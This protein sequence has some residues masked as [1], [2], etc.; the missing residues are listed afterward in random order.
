[1]R[2]RPDASGSGS[3]R[4]F[5]TWARRATY[6]AHS[7]EQPAP[8]YGGVVTIVALMNGGALIGAGALA[9]PDTSLAWVCALISLVAVPGALLAIAFVPS[10]EVDWPEWLTLAAGLGVLA[11]LLGML[12]LSYLPIRLGPMVMVTWLSTL[13]PALGALALKRNL[14]WRAPAGCGRP[15]LL[16]VLLLLLVAAIP[17]LPGL[18]YSEFQGDETEVILQATGIVQGLTDTLFYHGK[19]PG[20][21]LIVAAQYGL[22]GTLSEGAARLPFALAGLFG[23]LAVYLAAHRLLGRAGALVAGLFIATNGY[24]VAFSRITQYQ[25][26]VFLLGVLAVWCALRWAQGGTSI[27]PVLAGA[28]AAG[29]ALAHYDAVFVLPPIALIAL[30]RSGPRMLLDWRLMRPWLTGAGV[31]LAI[32][33]CFFGPY[34]ASPLYG[35]ATSRIADRVGFGFPRNNLSAIAASALL[36]VS[37]I[38]LALLAVA[39]VPGG[40]LAVVQRLR[41]GRGAPLS[42]A[43]PSGRAWLVG[44]VWCALPLLFYAFVARKPGTHVHVTSLGL[45]ILAGAGT[46]TVWAM[47]PVA[48]RWVRAGAFAALAGGVVILGGYLLP[49]YVQQKPELVRTGHLESFPLYWAPG[50]DVPQK[51]RFGFPYEAGWKAVGALFA[52]G[53]LGGSYDSNEQQQVTYWYTRGAWR[54]SAD[55]R[56]FVLAEDVQDEVDVPRKRI[57]AEYPL[58][59]VVTVAGQPKLRIHER[60]APS[61]Q[62]P[63]TWTAESLA[64]RFDRR[65]STPLPDP[66]SWA[67]GVLPLQYVVAPARFGAAV[68]LLGYRLYAENPRPGGVVRVDLFWHPYVTADDGYRIDVRLGGQTV[69]ATSDGPA[70]DKTRADREWRAGQPFAQRISLPLAATAPPGTYPLLVSVSRLGG[71]GEALPATSDL[72]VEAG[73][74]RLGE[75]AV[76]DGSR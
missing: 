62:K 28:L 54:C 30:G 51:E 2:Y 18:G 55:P 14:Y 67:R 3:L 37:A 46:G 63:M 73:L 66:G 44:L 4:L 17:R 5:P 23:V 42:S 68:E 10:D 16:D 72:P 35:L 19:G 8:R 39:I 59:G 48:S 26:L 38:Y 43:G 70:C 76:A 60:G 24:F 58:V 29:G 6:R 27:W 15:R 45:A 1:M 65:L 61:G 53:T 49:V 47:L 74:V 69:V 64:E 31:G 36:Y 22:V 20:E 52:D 7:A 12:L 50:D 9:I 13:T 32:L 11:L 34:L 41:Y 75:I 40:L 57:A 25:S 71:Q 33:A 56:Y 21:V